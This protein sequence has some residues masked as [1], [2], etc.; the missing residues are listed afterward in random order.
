MEEKEYIKTYLDELENVTPLG[1]EENV[2]LVARLRVGEDVSEKLIEGNL[3][4]VPGIV[5]E[6]LESG[7]P[8]GDLISEGNM[9]LMN[10]ARGLAEVDEVPDKIDEF[11]VS[12]IREAI[13]NFIS[14][15]GRISLAAAKME[16][17]ANRLFEITKDFEDENGRPATLAELAELMGMSEDEVENILR[18]S[19][20]AMM[21]GDVGEDESK[22]IT[23]PK[24]EDG[25]DEAGYFGDG[26]RNPLIDGWGDVD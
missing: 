6:Y 24:D 2:K 14:E 13:E 1:E 7:A 22:Q 4:L 17:E 5:S 15:E 16:E 21:L 8:V 25:G 23:E 18:V 20:S 11:F 9:A 10:A 26:K 19:Y 12:K 3:Y